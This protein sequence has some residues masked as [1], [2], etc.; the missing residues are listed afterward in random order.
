MSSNQAAWI[1]EARQQL[2]VGPA[3]TPKPGPG[4]LVIRSHAVAINPVDWKVQDYG[5]FIQNYP[6]ILGEDVAGIVEEVGEGVTRFEK[7]QRVIAHLLSLKTAN[8][9]HSGFQLYPVAQE[10]ATAAIPDS[11]TFEQAATLPLAVSTA[12][13][14]LY[15]PDNLGLPLPSTSPESIGKTLLV[16][17]AASSVGATAVQLAVAS[18]LRVI[19]TASPA[20]HQ[21][22]KDLGA[23]AVF[24]YRS[25]TVVNDI[26]NELRGK[27][28]A[29]AYDT[30]SEEATF[31]PLSAIAEELGGLPAASVLPYENPSE[32]FKPKFVT[33]SSIVTVPNEKIG[34]AIWEDYVP[35]ALASGQLQGKPDP[36]V[37]G[38][39]LDKIQHAF[40]VQKAGVSGK[41]IIVTL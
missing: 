14:G 41:K 2:T 10:N 31:G 36:V 12:S 11:L 34:Q 15:L 37:V 23:S 4:E 24:D 18:G 26:V 6:F 40:D 29:G 9:A 25:P 13:V 33:A 27:E 35:K 17:G 20:N 28:I 32:A 19:A 22:I 16:W 30:I 3:P 39:G 7:G 8:A 38:H 21:F 1:P 5:I